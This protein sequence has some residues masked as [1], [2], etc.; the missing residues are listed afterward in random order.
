MPRRSRTPPKSFRS[1]R[2]R[3]ILKEAF[4]ERN[5]LFRSFLCANGLVSSLKA[6]KTFIDILRGSKYLDFKYL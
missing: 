3:R 2:K 4:R 6:G 1:N 5:S